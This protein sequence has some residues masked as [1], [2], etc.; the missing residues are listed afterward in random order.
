MNRAKTTKFKRN[1]VLID[2]KM[3]FTAIIQKEDDNYVAFCPEVGTTSQGGSIEEA[4]ANL[5]ESTALYLKEFPISEEEKPLLTVFEI[6]NEKT[7]KAL[8][9]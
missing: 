5:K 7:A 1:H 2:N 6:K 4:L 3:A 8:G 9:T